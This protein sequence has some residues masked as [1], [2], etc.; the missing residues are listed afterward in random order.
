[1]YTIFRTAG[2]RRE[3]VLCSECVSVRPNSSPFADV[4]HSDNSGYSHIFSR[5]AYEYNHIHTDSL[6]GFIPCKL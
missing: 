6:S 5:A 2:T 3:L 1:M 4:Q